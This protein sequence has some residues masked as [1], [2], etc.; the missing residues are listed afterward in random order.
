MLKSN[1]IPLAAALTLGAAGAQDIP[2]PTIGAAPGTSGPTA[3]FTTLDRNRDGTI[4]KSEARHDKE[5]VR[6]FDT[7]DTVRDGKLSPAEFSVMEAD[8]PHKDT[9]AD[10]TSKPSDR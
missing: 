6:Q 7:L 3:N 4:D 5:V 2:A 10:A 8:Y 1:W 9:R